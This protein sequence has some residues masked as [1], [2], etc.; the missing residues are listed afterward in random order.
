MVLS[1]ISQGLVSRAHGRA[2]VASSVQVT[3]PTPPTRGRL[4][5]HQ[6]IEVS[7][8]GINDH[9]HS[10]NRHLHNALVSHYDGSRAQP[11]S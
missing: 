3:W 7:T 4:P 11:Y 5:T 8:T 10:L 6:H 9:S 2:E 1:F